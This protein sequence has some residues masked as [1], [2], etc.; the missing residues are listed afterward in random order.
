[1]SG[2]GSRQGEP[3]PSSSWTIFA[4]G[5]PV[6]K[7]YRSRP[8]V[9]NDDAPEALG[10]ASGYKPE[11]IGKPI[12]RIGGRSRRAISNGGVYI[13][14]LGLLSSRGVRYGSCS[15]ALLNPRRA[16]S[17]PPRSP[18]RSFVHTVRRRHPPRHLPHQPSAPQPIENVVG[19]I[20]QPSPVPTVADP[21]TEG[22]EA[23]P[24][25]L[26][27]GS[28]SLN[29]SGRNWNVVMPEHFTKAE[30]AFYTGDP[31]GLSLHPAYAGHLKINGKDVVRWKEVYT[32][33]ASRGFLFHDS[34]TNTDV[35]PLEDRDRGFPRCDQ[36]SSS[37][38]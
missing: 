38:R 10:V 33:G 3:I 8:V 21:T 7:T 29:K 31:S 24:I 30:V 32:D 12:P 6:D 4:D 1:M 11:T 15:E 28:F 5:K 22:I 25:V 26:D 37:G 9:S 27:L 13:L 2:S 36:V 23:S 18:R 20:E 35:R 14:E 34:T 17:E 16:R 19:K